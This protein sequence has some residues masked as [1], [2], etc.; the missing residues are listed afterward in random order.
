VTAPNLAASTRTDVTVPR[1]VVDLVARG[2]E[3]LGISK[4]E[5]QR[6][7]L[8]LSVDALAGEDP[9]S[10]GPAEPE[11]CPTCHQP[12]RRHERHEEGGATVRMTL[13][14]PIG[15]LE[16]MRAVAL[17]HFNGVASHAFE[18]GVRLLAEAEGV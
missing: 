18:A 8:R 17:R 14:A 16:E 11:R 15:L 2:A 6:R 3:K 5:F 9:L 13:Y 1:D 10:E 7:S 12:L 4:C